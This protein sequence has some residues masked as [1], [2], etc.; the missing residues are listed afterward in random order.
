MKDTTN[1]LRQFAEVHAPIG[2]LYGLFSKFMDLCAP[3]ME[4]ARRPQTGHWIMASNGE[5]DRENAPGLSYPEIYERSVDQL[6]LLPAPDTLKTS[7]TVAS[8]EG[9]DD[10]L[11]WDLFDQ[12]PSIGWAET[13]LWDAMTQLGP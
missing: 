13:G 10:N 1:D 12:Q 2:K 6:N 11:M 9:W 7:S 5:A 4:N 3:L 8:T